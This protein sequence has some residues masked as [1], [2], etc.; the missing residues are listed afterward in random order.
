MSTKPNMLQYLCFGCEK[1]E[2]HYELYRVDC[3]I[4]AYYGQEKI[5][6]Y[7]SGYERVFYKSTLQYDPRINTLTK[8]VQVGSYKDVGEPKI[9]LNAEFFDLSSDEKA[10][11]LRKGVYDV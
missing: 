5:S 10:K 9:K 11:Y 6:G 4:Y 7:G 8:M 1:N 2:P 3:I